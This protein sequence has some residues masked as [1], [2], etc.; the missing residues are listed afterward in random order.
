MNILLTNKCNQSCNYCFLKSDLASNE[1]ESQEI[2][3]ENFEIALEYA[4]DLIDMGVKNQLNLLGG[5]PT[6]H[7]KFEYLLNKSINQKSK[8]NKNRFINVYIFSNGLFDIELSKFIGKRPCGIM[9]NINH[10]DTYTSKL[11][12]KLEN[13][14]IKMSSIRQNAFPITLSIN[15]YKPHQDFSYLLTLA[16]K[17]R[18]K[19]IRVD[20]A[21][22]DYK[23]ANKYITND[24]IS[25]IIPTI[26]D[27][28][29]SCRKKGIK[30]VT[31]CCLPVCLFKDQQLKK[32]IDN[33]VSLSFS[34]TGAID[35]NFDM[36]VWYCIPMRSLKFG[37]LTDYKDA[38]ELTYALR[39]R[40]Q[41]L[42][43]D[44]NSFEQCESCKWRTL[45]ICQ[46]GCL[47]NKR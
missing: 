13:N 17:S 34:C 24:K 35:I 33:E 2:S 10:P 3:I 25:T 30:L 11:W 26:I 12:A 39:D 15:I 27:L 21:K 46:G 31:D 22:T 4:V 29:N 28:S 47:A 37:K 40:T 20:I 1:I 38:H 6:L 16:E 45:K 43:W 23:K 36:E 44:I 8:A 7:S 19:Y 5:E 9:L 32:L 18:I 14:I 42:R 41:H